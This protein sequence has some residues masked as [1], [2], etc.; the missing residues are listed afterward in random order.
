M[1]HKK[2]LMIEGDKLET[3]TFVNCDLGQRTVQ[4]IG[5][6]I[7]ANCVVEDEIDW[8]NRT[9]IV[10]LEGVIRL[11][12]GTE[13]E[14]DF[15]RRLPLLPGVFLRPGK[16]NFAVWASPDE[17]HLAILLEKVTETGQIAF[18]RLI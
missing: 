9:A 12:V 16:T 10:L 5:R 13:H 15:Y 7:V 11:R 18:A 8:E 14:N 17:H 6:R 4:S 2:D 3:F 1:R